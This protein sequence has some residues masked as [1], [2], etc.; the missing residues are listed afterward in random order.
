MKYLILGSE[1]QIGHALKNFLIENNQEVLEFDIVNSVEQDLRLYD[2]NLLK[3]YIEECDFIFFLAWDVGGSRYLQKYQDTYDFII[4]NLKITVNVFDLI[5]KYKKP[6]IFASSQ[7]ASM[8]YSSYGMTKAL[9]EKVVKSLG[10]ITVKFWNVYGP[11]RDLEK[12]HVVTDFI[13]KAKNNKKIDMLTNGVEVRQFLHVDDCSKCLFDLST[14]YNDLNPQDEFHITS[15]EW[16]SVLEVAKIIK[17]YYPEAEIIPGE[18]VDTVQLDA[19]NEPDNNILKYWKPALSLEEGI[20]KVID[21]LED[22]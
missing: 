8:S 7:M 22:L 13:L 12:S 6:F 16:S 11:E 20:K 10:G 18:K 14:Q 19:R 17:K 5:N 3:N 9:A 21:Q 4:N 15:F 2:N 1:G